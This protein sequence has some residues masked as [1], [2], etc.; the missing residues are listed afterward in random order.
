MDTVT[1]EHGQSERRAVPFWRKARVV[2]QRRIWS[3]THAMPYRA[4]VMTRSK[5]HQV[6]EWFAKDEAQL[7]WVGRKG[8]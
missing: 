1:L 3:T 2:W 6:N 4:R 7:D 8:L 5:L